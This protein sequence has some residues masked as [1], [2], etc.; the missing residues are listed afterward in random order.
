MLCSVQL[1]CT[2]GKRKRIGAAAAAAA[3]GNGLGFSVLRQK[4]VRDSS[5]ISL[6]CK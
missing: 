4:R 2:E 5:V 1:P 6:V 3:K